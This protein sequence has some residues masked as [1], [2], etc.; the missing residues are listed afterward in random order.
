MRIIWSPLAVD[1]VRDISTYIALDKPSVAIT[2]ANK[3]FSSVDQLLEHPEIGRVVPEINR[4]EIREL[5]HGSYRLIYKLKS[6][7]ILILVVK[8]YRQQL[9]ETEIKA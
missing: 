6:K 9:S 7:E 3:I 8:S 1:Q 4:I 2:W 5:V